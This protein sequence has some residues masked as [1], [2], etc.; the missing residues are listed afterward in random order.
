MRHMILSTVLGV[1][2]AV[3]LPVSADIIGTGAPE[4]ASAAPDIIGTG[5][6]AAPDIIGTGES[7]A[8]D[9]IGTGASAAPDIIG[10]GDSLW[11]A[12]WLVV[13]L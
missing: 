1:L 11:G 8:P 6:S 10:T 3:S 4:P 7:V 9:I 12:F 5:A 2:L 13:G